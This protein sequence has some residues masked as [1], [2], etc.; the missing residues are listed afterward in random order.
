MFLVKLRR[1]QLS[2][3][4]RSL[5]L[6]QCQCILISGLAREDAPFQYPVTASK[7]SVAGKTVGIYQDQKWCICIF[8]KLNITKFPCHLLTATFFTNHIPEIKS[9]CLLYEYKHRGISRWTCVLFLNVQVNN[10]YW[11]FP[12]TAAFC[13]ELILVFIFWNYIYLTNQ[14]VACKLPPSFKYIVK[15][16]PYQHQ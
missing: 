12:I 1:Q 3:L 7:L 5:V 2:R 6:I 9:H 14:V 11:D 15:Y 10:T 8:N 16:V 4:R 13:F